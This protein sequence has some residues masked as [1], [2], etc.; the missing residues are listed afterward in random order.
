MLA[1]AGISYQPADTLL[2][3]HG[4]VYSAIPSAYHDHIEV[5]LPTYGSI[6]DPATI[7]LDYLGPTA[8]SEQFISWTLWASGLTM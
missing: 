1:P 4:I 7:I 5:T 8:H 6:L 2:T 3:K